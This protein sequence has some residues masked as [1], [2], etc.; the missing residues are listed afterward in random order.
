MPLTQV[1][2]IARTDPTL[3]DSIEKLRGCG[4]IFAALIERAGLEVFVRAAYVYVLGRPADPSGIVTYVR[5]LGSGEL[6][7]FDF[8]S[9]LCDSDEFRAVPRVLIAPT[10]P[11]FIFAAL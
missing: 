8:L 6:A 4:S 1:D 7:P 3:V 5:M 9:A 10:E 11:G 2:D